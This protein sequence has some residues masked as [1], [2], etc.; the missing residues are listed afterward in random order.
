MLT[1]ENTLEKFSLLEPEVVFIVNSDRFTRQISGLSE[2]YGVDL[3][4]VVL[5]AVIGDLKSEEIASYLE[6][7]KEL[8]ADKAKAIADELIDQVLKPLEN[9]LMLLNADPDKASPSLAEEKNA[10]KK[11]FAE[12]L[13]AE[14]SE[15]FTIKNAFNS[16]IFDI[17]EHD[18]NYK[19][20]LE[21]L[22]YENSEV[23]T[24]KSIMTAGKASQPTIGNWL[25]DFI[26]KKGTGDF[27]TIAL[28]DYMTNSANTKELSQAEKRKLFDLLNLYRNIKFFP[29]NVA[30]KPIED[31]QILPFDM[32]EADEFVARRKKNDQVE[33]EM[34]EETGEL[35][36]DQ[37]LFQHDWSK[38]IGIER[39][40]L[41]EDMGVSLKDFIRWL[42]EKK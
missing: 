23:L 28:S 24:G 37:K 40:A 25:K 9:R 30:G 41:L 29:E 27:N 39:R 17:L 19:R 15:N 10:F 16:R 13:L 35:T 21:R 3:N 12:N 14:M 22:M 5:R 42:G 6:Q 32:A 38:I 26:S 4:A 36:L 8:E 7:E 18:L 1:L 11:I 31:W 34:A 33:E 20:E 2:K